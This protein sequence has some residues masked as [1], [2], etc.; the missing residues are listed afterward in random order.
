M[1]VNHNIMA[2]NTRR[3]LSMNSKGLATRLERL[4]SGLRINKAADDA[5]GLSVS[6]GFRAEIGGVQVGTRNAEQGANMI[7]TAEGALNEVSAILIRMRELAVQG[8]SS[9][10]NDDNR[11][12]LNAEF[13]QLSAEIDRITASTK[14][15]NTSLLSGFGNTVSQNVVA[16]TALASATHWPQ[17]YSIIAMYL[18]AARYSVA[19]PSS[20]WYCLSFHLKEIPSP[21]DAT[22]MSHC[23]NR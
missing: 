13:N 14:Y 5:S 17:Y 9:T 19:A 12:A 1:V 3:H 7:Q 18:M 15:N 8:A 23:R 4:S 20:N 2:M 21:F 6:E 22:L 11:S 16:S 10:V